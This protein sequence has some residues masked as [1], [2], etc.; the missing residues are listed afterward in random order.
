MGRSDLLLTFDEHFDVD[1]RVTL[2]GSE[3]PEMH[4]HTGL[5]VGRPASVQPSVAFE[6]DER[7]GLPLLTRSR[8]LNVVM[9]VEEHGRRP[10]RSVDRCEHGGMSSGI[11]QQFR[12]RGTGFCEE[13]SDAFGRASDL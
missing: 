8:R 11:L 13:L 7:L 6:R 5:V 3:R 9:G 2:E 4:D 10:V 1:G 12:I